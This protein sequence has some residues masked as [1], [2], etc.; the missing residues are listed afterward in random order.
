MISNDCYNFE[1]NMSALLTNI[2][3]LYEQSPNS[4]YYNIDV[5]KYQMR[6]LQGAKSAPLQLVS[7]WKCDPQST[8]LKIDY[9][10]NSSSLAQIEPL[11][12]I[13]YAVNIDGG[14]HFM[15]S[16]P[17]GKWFVNRL[18]FLIF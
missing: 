12:N 14:P 17:E 18:F 7:Y 10:Y 8:G 3:R 15:Q 11:R 4:R 16:R 2:R 1:V 13:S 5:L 9:K 6:C